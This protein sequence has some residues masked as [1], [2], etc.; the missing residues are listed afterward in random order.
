MRDPVKTIEVVNYRKS[1]ELFVPAE[2]IVRREEI[3][4]LYKH[5]EE[6]RKWTKRTIAP[7]ASIA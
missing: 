2:T 5:L 7:L 4:E 3:P 1:G 6:K